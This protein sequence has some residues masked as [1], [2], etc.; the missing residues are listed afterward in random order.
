MVLSEKQFS[1]LYDIG[2]FDII[3]D[4]CDIIIDE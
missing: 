4:K 2:V 1:E 3:N